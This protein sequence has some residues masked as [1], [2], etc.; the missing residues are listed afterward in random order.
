MSKESTIVARLKQTLAGGG[1][2]VIRVGSDRE[3]IGDERS[4]NSRN[5]MMPSSRSE[6]RCRGR[7]L[8]VVGGG[9]DL[10]YIHASKQAAKL[11][12]TN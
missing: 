3:F 9:I 10:F 4:K 2:A 6:S 12:Q 7:R 1:V 5:E 11:Q 8:V